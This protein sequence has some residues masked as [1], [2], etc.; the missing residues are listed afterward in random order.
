M[1]SKF[2]S[3]GIGSTDRQSDRTHWSVRLSKALLIPGLALTAATLQHS[4]VQ[5]QSRFERRIQERIQKRRLQE[6]SKLTDTQKQ[7]LFEAR[8]NWA[9]SSYDQRLALLKSGQSCLENAQTFD[10]GKTCRQKQQQA[11]RQLLEQAR[12]DMDSESQRLGLSPLRSVSPF[13][14]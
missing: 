9:L 2:A 11:R 1:S 13:G 10:A 12:Q 5:A 3:D 7:Q 8:R 6:E 14:F 4:E